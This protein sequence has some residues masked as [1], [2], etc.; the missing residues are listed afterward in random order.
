[1]RVCPSACPL[2]LRV[3]IRSAPLHQL[4]P[5]ECPFTSGIPITLPPYIRYSHQSAPLYSKY[6]FLSYFPIRAP[7]YI[8]FPVRVSLS[9][10][11]AHLCP[12]NI[13]WAIVPLTKC[14]HQSAP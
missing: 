12:L 6:S 14:A 9:T 2:A 13:K 4:S 10:V 5:S 7:L 11:C 8:I 3:T 1:N